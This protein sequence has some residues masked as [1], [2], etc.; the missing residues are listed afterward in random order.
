M[1]YTPFVPICMYYMPPP[2]NASF[3]SV[4]KSGI[5]ACGW[6]ENTTPTQVAKGE[7]TTGASGVF[8][9][10]SEGETPPL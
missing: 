8:V 9:P 3:P 1:L 2:R 7:T 6:K 10:T 4:R 5:C